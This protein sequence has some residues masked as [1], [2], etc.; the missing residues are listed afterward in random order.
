MHISES[1]IAATV[2]SLRDILQEAATLALSADAAIAA[3]RRNLA[4]GTL[5]PLEQL[6]PAAQALLGASLTL[7]RREPGQDR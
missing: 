7:H 4:I 3:G 5:L 1:T 2:T 6:L